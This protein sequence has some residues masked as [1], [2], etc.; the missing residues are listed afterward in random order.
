VLKA[1]EFVDFKNTKLSEAA[2][3]NRAKTKAEKEKE[4]NTQ[5]CS[6]VC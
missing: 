5:D 6:K 3:V 4:K 1:P 2:K